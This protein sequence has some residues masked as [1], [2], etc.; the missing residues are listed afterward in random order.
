MRTMFTT[1]AALLIAFSALASDQ[2]VTARAQLSEIE[3]TFKPHL[4]LQRTEREITVDGDLSDLGWRSAARATDFVEVRPGENLPPERSSEGWITYDNHHLYVALIARD[5][6][7]E[8]RVTMTDRDNIFQDD[9]FGIMFDTYGDLAWSYEVLV[10]PLGIQGDLRMSHGNEDLS[11]DIVWES[12]GQV[13]DS[14]YQVEIAIPFSSLRFPEKDEQTWRMNFWRDRRRDARYKYSWAAQDRDN[15]CFECQWGYVHGITGISPSSNLELLPNLIT[16]HFG[17]R[18]DLDDPDSD[19]DYADP[20]AELSMNL[21][22][23]LSSNTTAEMTFNPDFSQVESDADQITA[24]TTFALWYS[25]RRPF[26]QEGSELYNTWINVVYTRSINAPDIAAKFNSRSGR[27]SAAVLTA[28]DDQSPVV[29][30]LP[31]RSRV[32]AGGQSLVNI[33]RVKHTLGESSHMGLLVTDRRFDAGDGSGS[34]ASGDAQIR[35]NQNYHFEVQGAVS[36]TNEINDT[37]ISSSINDLYFDRNSR[38]A[39]FDGESYWGHA[40]YLSLER[41]GRHWNFDIDYFEYSPTF[42]ADNGFISRNDQRS[43]DIWTGLIFRP[44]REVLLTYEPQLSVG[45]IW[46]H[47]GQFRD[48]WLRPSIWIE[49]VG[50]TNLYMHYLI[51]EEKFGGRL[52]KGISRFNMDV[53]TAFTQVIRGGFYYGEGRTLY[54]DFD[55]PRLGYSRDFGFWLEFKPW[56]RLVINPRVNYARMDERESSEEIYEGY[57]V[58]S[59]FNYQFTRSLFVRLIVQYNDFG[60]DLSFEPLLTYRINPFSL[61]YIGSTQNYYADLAEQE[62]PTTRQAQHYFAKF[63]YLFRI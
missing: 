39:A 21:K 47:D 20:E 25:E 18:T 61:F 19:F 27:T 54:R 49:L 29:V 17:Q 37:S 51:S 45:R 50:Q 63:Q 11:F 15:P 3:P 35:L 31:E 12:M 2:V 60:K 28:W 56:Q 13:T 24:N 43:L 34:V 4:T 10:N 62:I 58:R 48:E 30:P 41:G 9:Y 36:H 23:G 38:S 6:P 53:N 52:I 42:R 16:S 46:E 57:I 26:F 1:L 8:V 33:G 5:D 22:Y 14:G 32:F 55:D 7:S 40:G 59:R 44:N